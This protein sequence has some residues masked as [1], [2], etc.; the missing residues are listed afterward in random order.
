MAWPSRHPQSL[1]LQRSHLGKVKKYET[2]ATRLC[3]HEVGGPSPAIALPDQ[4][5]AL[6]SQAGHQA[7]QRTAEG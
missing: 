5:G 4:L 3:P 2:Q 7:G 1:L 6:C